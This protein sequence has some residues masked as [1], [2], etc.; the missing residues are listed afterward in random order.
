MMS[1]DC[2]RLLRIDSSLHGPSTSVSRVVA[3]IFEAA[4]TAAGGAVVR[5][6]LGA[7]PI[8]YL[9][10]DEHTAMFIPEEHR[11]TEQHDAQARAAALADELF[12][13]DVLL[14]TSPLYNLNIPA[15]LKTWIDHVFTD[16]RLFPGYG[17]TRPLAGRTAVVI[18]PQGQRLRTGGADVG[19]GLRRALPAAD[20]GRHPRLRPA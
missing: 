4:W 10:E 14:L 16:I 15:T 3:D 11:T 17:I 8:G 7:Q 20:L 2:S 19:L 9:T 5:R 6:D 12:D 1:L 13:A 18:P